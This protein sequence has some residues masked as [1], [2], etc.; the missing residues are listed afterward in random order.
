VLHPILISNLVVTDFIDIVLVF[1]L[2]FLITAAAAAA[3]AADE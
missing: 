2:A 3:T 1:L